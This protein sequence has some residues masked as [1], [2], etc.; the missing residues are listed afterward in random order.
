MHPEAGISSAGKDILHHEH[1]TICKKFNPEYL[2]FL[3]CAER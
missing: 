1:L 3:H 2:D